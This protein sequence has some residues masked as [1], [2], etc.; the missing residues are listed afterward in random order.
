M[1]SV[2]PAFGERTGPAFGDPLGRS[3]FGVVLRPRIVFQQSGRGVIGEVRPRIPGGTLAL[4]GPAS[5]AGRVPRRV[6]IGAN[7]RFSLPVSLRGA[8]RITARLVDVGPAP[9]KGLKRQP[10][11]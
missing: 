4:R 6:R 11:R 9:P 1:W 8:E 3:V 10:G 2:W 7:S 5:L